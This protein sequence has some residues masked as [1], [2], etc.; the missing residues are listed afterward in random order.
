MRR[1]WGC[2]DGRSCVFGGEKERVAEG[3]FFFFFVNCLAA[4]SMCPLRY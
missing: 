2:D 1:D 4:G 3:G